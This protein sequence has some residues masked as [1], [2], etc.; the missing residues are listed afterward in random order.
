[1]KT[2]L[3]LLSLLCLLTVGGTAVVTVPYHTNNDWLVKLLAKAR[4]VSVR[5]AR[6]YG[7]VPAVFA[8]VQV[9]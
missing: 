3:L 7:K 6:S 2:F 5:Y 9:G 1:M 4:P 8:R